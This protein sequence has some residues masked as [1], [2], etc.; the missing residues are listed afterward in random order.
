M[1]R[2][3]SALS[4]KSELD[5]VGPSPVPVLGV[6]RGGQVAAVD[7]RAAGGV[8]DHR[9]VAEELAHQLQVGRLA[10]AGAGAGELE[11]RLE[12]LRA[13]DHVDLDLRAVDLG[14]ARGRSRSWPARRSRWSSFGSMLMAL[15]LA[16][17][18][19]RAGQT[20]TQTPQ[21]VQSSGATW[22]VRCWP[23]I[24]LAGVGPRLEA[25][26]ACPPGPTRG[27]PWCGWPRAGRPARRGRT[28][29]RCR[30]PRSGSTARCSASRTG[31]CRWG[32]CRRPAG[33]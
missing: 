25:C 27:R 8:G 3:N 24:L 20:S 33:R 30:G 4:S 14:N 22:T 26:R 6:R 18:L 11:E 9:P 31:R 21:P 15:C 19:L 16:T 13:L 2:P 7:R 5:Q 23:G 32:R 1:P 28:G 12:Q 17:S 10:A 29:C